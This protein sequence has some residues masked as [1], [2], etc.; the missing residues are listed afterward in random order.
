MTNINPFIA[1]IMVVVKGLNKLIRS[2]D[3]WN[4]KGKIKRSNTLLSTRN[5][6][7]SKIE[8]IKG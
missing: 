6:L 4:E 7:D 8:I 3:H 1:I 5:T 2:R